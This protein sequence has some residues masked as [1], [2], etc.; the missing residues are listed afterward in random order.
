MTQP[1]TR[2]AAVA[3]AA[4]ALAASTLPA[5]AENPK[6]S[7]RLLET[8]DLHVNVF[9]YDYYRDKPDDTVGLAKTASLIK[10]AR[11]EA[12]N[13][14]LFDNGDIIQGSPMG[15]FMFYKKGLKAGE[16]HPIIAAMN[17]LG[18]AAC[19]LGN[20]EF[21]YGL[22]YL[23]AALG[24]ANFPSTCCNLLG[25]DGKP[26]A[27]PWLVVEKD[28]T[29]ASGAAHKLRVGVIG[30]L[31][32]QVMQWDKGNLEG[33]V[34][35]TDIVQAAEKYVPELRAQKVDVVVA[36]CHSGISRSARKSAWERPAPA[37][38][39]QNR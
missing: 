13:S 34:T 16:V 19:T 35:T 3:T 7:L 6:V 23:D 27:K 24:G 30:F 22:P 31:P 12:K 28:V 26:R 37:A 10:A 8:S 32:P 1:I 11:A 5:R 20:H 14:I 36:L 38:L 29:D 21:N 15:D 17:E 25:L 9:P 4:A 39:P 18:Y 33:K 2:R